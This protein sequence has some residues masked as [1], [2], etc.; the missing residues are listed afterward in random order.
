MKRHS[1]FF[2]AILVCFLLGQAV[3]CGAQSAAPDSFEQW[4]EQYGAWDRLEQEYATESDHDSTPEVILKRAEVYL[5]LNSPEKALEIIEM[6][7]SFSDNATEAQR[8]WLGGKAQRALG[9]LPKAVLWFSQSASFVEDKAALSRQFK[10]EPDLENVWMDVWLKLFWSYGANTTLSRD[11][12]K[13][14]L[15]KVQQLGMDVWGGR[16]WMT[17]GEALKSRPDTAGDARSLQAQPNATSLVNKADT[18]AVAKALALVSLEKFDDA[19]TAATT[20]GPEPVRA[21][22]TMVI[23]FLESG[24]LPP[25]LNVFSQGNYLKANAFWEGNMLAPYSVSRSHW[26]LGNPE[27]G[28]W[29]KFRNNILAM[30]LDEANRAIDNELGSMLISEQTAALL[31]S[32]KLALALSDGDFISTATAWNK[33]DK[34]KLPLA[35]QLAGT[36]LFK[37][38]L[39][40]VL[41]NTPSEAFTIQPILAALCS[42][43]G[44]TAS[45]MNDAPFWISAPQDNLKSLSQR[46]WP[47]DKLLLLAYW[48]HEFS[49]SPSTVLA[50]RAAFLFDDTAFGVE[51]VLYLADQAVRGNQL[52]L[53]AYYLNAL[54]PDA[55]PPA[56]RMQWYDV[57]LRLELE[58]GRNDAA[59]ETFAL[60]AASQGKVPTMTRLRMALLYQQ[61]RDFTAARDQLLTMWADR[62][63]LTTTLQAEILF[64]LGEGEQG[65]HNTEKALDYYL[66]LA[67]QYPQENIWALT[68]MYRASLIY[69]RRGKYDTAK[70]LLTTVVKRADRKEQREA[71]KARIDAIDKKMGEKKT[72]ESSGALVYP[73]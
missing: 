11:T 27:S 49:S 14:A 40:N 53:G 62:A 58:S 63:N 26:L 15:E 32:F 51:S 56:H 42:A 17:A 52:Q 45:G 54:K 31:N 33:I 35:L 1:P 41:P 10:N 73:F 25:D 20:I 43:A 13:D 9:D 60:M 19:R 24:T 65:L 5:N 34:Q 55:L 69:E 3:P 48:Q 28:P 22:W 44:S 12:Q 46:D 30:P 38:D 50:K 66:R 71:A 67:W 64:W 36:L 70:R 7:P 61:K 47:M 23:A 8:L 2:S 39:K 72:D 21:F 59:F 18:D 6:T 57:R 68:A 37:D 4:L 16:Y 29:T